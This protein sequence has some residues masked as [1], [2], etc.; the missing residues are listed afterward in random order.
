MSGR[1]SFGELTRHFTQ[2]G[3]QRIDA[4]KSEQRTAMPLHQLRRTMELSQRDLAES[5]KENQP[6]IAEPE[7]RDDVY[8]SSLHSYIEA[9]GGHLMIVAEFPGGEVAIT[10]FSHVGDAEGGY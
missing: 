1:F 6:A 9:M 4:I 2:E 3:R 10:N 5:L 7:Q 8:V